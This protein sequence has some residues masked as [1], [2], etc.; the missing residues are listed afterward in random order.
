MH[1]LL[2]TN[3]NKDFKTEDLEE[4][5]EKMSEDHIGYQ[6]NFIK[7]IDENIISASLNG[8]SFK[9]GGDIFKC[10]ER[11]PDNEEENYEKYQQSCR[12]GRYRFM[13]KGSLLEK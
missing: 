1:E 10:W 5:Y 13:L 4:F 6:N 8:V 12:I 2:E 9:K 7:K 3:K 11:T